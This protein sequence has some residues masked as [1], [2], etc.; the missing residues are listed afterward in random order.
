MFRRITKMFLVLVF[1]VALIA[2]FSQPALAAEDTFWVEMAGMDVVD[3]G[4]SGYEGGKWYWYDNYNWWNT[5]FYDHP[6]DQDK[7]KKIHLELFVKPLVPGE[8]AI[9]DIVY[10]WSTG[11]WSD[12]GYERPPLPED[13]PTSELEDKYIVRSYTYEKGIPPY[14]WIASWYQ[15]PDEGEILIDD[16]IIPEYNPEWVS[17]DI[18]GTN[19][20]MKGTIKHECVPIPAT[21][22]LLGSGL[23]GLIGIGRRKLFNA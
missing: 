12:L 4:G 19:I 6:F 8:F 5:W 2:G 3:Y 22:L 23:I 20:Y 13:V 16:Y 9:V 21:L 11:A 17:I 10:N 18:W 7:W 1:A 14:H 15:P